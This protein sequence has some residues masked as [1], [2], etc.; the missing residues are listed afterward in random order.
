M[1]KKLDVQH[2][3]IVGSKGIPGNYGGYETFVDKLTEYHQNNPNLKYHVACKA[4]DTKTFEYHNA[5]CFDVKVPSIGP[6]QAIYYD[7]AALNQCVKYIR[8]HN[9]QHPIVYILACR[10]GPFADHFQKVIH[11]LGGKLYINPDGHE[12]MRAKWSAPVRKYWKISEQLMTKH[13]DLLICDSKNIEKYIHDEYGKYNPKT[14]FIAYGAETR[15]SKL[16]DDDPKLTAWYK[17][18]GLSPKSYYLVVGR[19]VPENN[20][21]TMIRE[22]MK[23]HSKR[24]FALI[25]NVS[26]KFLEELKE[27]THFDQ[28]PRIKFV[29]TVYDKE[30]LMK[31]RENA[32]GYFHGHE[33][34]GTNPSLLEALGSTDLNLLL[35]VGFNR[36]VAE[37]AALYWNK[38]PGNLASLIDQ[39]DNMNAGEI[40]ELGEKSSQRVVEAY[41]WQHIAD[42]YKQLFK[43]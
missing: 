25:T 38:Q 9:I 34:G 16:T 24:D 12:W 35:D 2:V 8:Q 31:I 3:F 23:S 4:K 26:D 28:D 37:D 39:A 40:T 27:K 19:F 32:Y 14:T 41:S 6:A 17:E 18:K 15:K 43:N 1:L 36:E 7:V 42:E 20:Y 5:D 13:C 33:V 11:K 22:F 30:L 10:I 29:G 21:E